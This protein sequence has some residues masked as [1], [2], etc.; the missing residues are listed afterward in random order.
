MIEPEAA[1]ENLQRLAADGLLGQFGM[2]EAVDYTP[3]R[4]PRGHAMAVVRSYMTHHQGMSLLS[5]ADLLLDHPLQRRFASDP[6][7]QATLMLLHERIPRAAQFLVHPAVSPLSHAAAET[8]APQIRVINRPDT[9][10]PEVQLLSNGRYHVLV[11][12]AGGGYSRWNDMAVTRWQEDPTRDHWGSFCYIRDTVTGTY[13][14]NTAQPALKR[15]DRYAAVFT[16]GRAEFHREDRVEGSLIETRTEIVVSPEDDIELRRIRLINRSGERRTVDVTSYAEVVLAAPVAD[17]LHPAFS[18]LFVQTEI[19]RAKRAVLC[20]RRPRALGEQSGWLFHLMAVSGA[21]TGEMSF[22]TD[23]ARFVGRG[24]TPADPRALA[25]RGQLSGSE[26]SV[27]DPVAAIRQVVVL[28]PDATAT[29]DLLTG[30]AAARETAE[31]LID[32]YQDRHLADRIFDLAWTHNQVVLQQFG[33]SEAQAQEYERLA[34]SVIFA[35]AAMRADAGVIL[36]NRRGQSGL[37]G[38]SISGDLPIVLLQIA[39]LANITLVR[40]LLQARAYWRL[41]GLVVDLVIWTEDQSGYRQQLHDAIMGLITAGVEANLLDRPGGIFLRHSDHISLED[42]LLLKS[43]AR[44]IIDDGRGSLS[45]QLKRRRAPEARIPELRPVTTRPPVARAPTVSPRPD[46]I[47]TNEIGGFTRDGREYVVTLARERTTP[48]PWVNVLANP[49]FGTVVSESGGGY[50]WS[51]NAHEFRV[52]P[53]HDDPVTDESGEAFYL[54]DEETGRF[55]SPTPLPAPGGGAYVS[56]HGFGYSVFEHDTAGIFSEMTI[57]VAMDAPVKFSVLK[58]RNDSGQTRRLSVTGYVEWVLGDLRPKCAMHVTTEIDPATGALLARNPYNSEFPD[59]VAFF[60]VDEANRTVTGDRGEFVGRNGSLRQPAAMTRARLS[61]RVGAA[62]DPC[63]AI[64]VGF[65]LAPGQERQFVFRMGVGG[66]IGEARAHVARFRGAASA[67]AALQSVWDY[68]KRT[69]GAVQVETPDESVNVL[70]NGWL[71]YQTL[72]CRLWARS[73]YYQSGGAF[74]FRDQLQDVTALLHAEPRLFRAHLLLCASRQFVE[75]DVQHWWHP[76]LGRGVR[77][78]CS[79]DYLWLPLA[80]CRYVF[81]TGDTGVLDETAPFLEGRAVNPGDE[82][83]YDLPGR[84][85]ESAS[86]YEHCVRAVRHGFRFGE[87]GLPLIGSGD[88]NDGMNRVGI[89]GKGESVWLAFFLC[90]VLRQFARL[91]RQRDDAAFA[92]ECDAVGRQLRESIERHGWDGAWYRRAYFDDGT[93]LGSASNL[94]CRIDSVAQSWSVLSGAGDPDRSRKAMDAV[95]DHLVRRRDGLVQLLDPPF[96]KSS[97][98][99]GYIRGYVPGVREN[100]GQ[101]THAAIW[102]SMAFAALGDAGRA[103]G[104]LTLINPANHSLSEDAAE[105][106]KVEPYVVAADVYA[107]SS[108]VGRGGWTWYTGSAGWM[109]RLIVESL[110]GVRLEVDK[111]HFRP[112]LPQHWSSFT[113]HYRYRETHYRIIVTQLPMADGKPSEGMT[114]V[115]DGAVQPD[116]AVPLVDDGQ[117]HA[118][119]ISVLGGTPDTG[120]GVATR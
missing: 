9:P 41:K 79:D 88:W 63:A 52:T 118:V 89:H 20:T 86:L 65:E 19:M 55:W 59:R 84:S 66:N 80:T 82:S 13:W 104:L 24:R 107:S 90:E 96:D 26:G 31:H 44:I 64:Q 115:V 53:W 105:R 68:W 7:C 101:Y 23:R 71:V 45:E 119:E 72:A 51:E 14:S 33:I 38:Y 73:G 8:A 97:L 37:W 16:E 22:E 56:R 39:D 10:V 77:T 36:R 75:G 112:C 48:A 78:R 21:A 108:H 6:Q 1:C 58:V 111:L 116:A 47:L 99:P 57:H 85:R 49:Q 60:D 17:A 114:V 62:L 12:A 92:E 70:A 91:A 5:I 76:P 87:H 32:R 34:G 40:Q 102:A 113:I 3:S 110:L 4:I 54:R 109:Y 2:Y 18:K 95:D 67:R 69:L 61:G 42:R 93:P 94:E 50:T 43:V 81:A 27:L 28:E 98:D 11:T 29:I 46:L 100:G 117:A 25:E 106:Y 120:K 74:G 83:Y 103:W 30:A 35:N 15:P